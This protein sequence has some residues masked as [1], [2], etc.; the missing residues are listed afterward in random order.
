MTRL[1][2]PKVSTK[3]STIRKRKIRPIPFPHTL[4]TN[5]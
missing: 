5:P 2:T 4:R 3:T 1:R